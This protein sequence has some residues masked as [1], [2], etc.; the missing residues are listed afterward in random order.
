MLERKDLRWWNEQQK[1]R[2]GVRHAGRFNP[3]LDV[4]RSI[5]QIAGLEWQTKAQDRQWWQNK[6]E[7]YITQFDV[8]WATGKQTQAC[9]RSGV[10]LLHTTCVPSIPIKAIPARRL[11]AAT[12]R[13]L[14][15]TAIILW[16]SFTWARWI[17]IAQGEFGNDLG[18]HTRRSIS[19]MSK[20]VPRRLPYHHQYLS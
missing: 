2:R 12:Q 13:L 9:L 19:E 6:T 7:D 14:S 15:A 1:L 20:S 16:T 8:Q 11:I 18:P 10:T 3:G 17:H 5:C 4:E